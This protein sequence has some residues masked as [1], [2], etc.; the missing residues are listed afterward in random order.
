MGQNSFVM[1]FRT[2]CCRS[3]LSPI[4]RSSSAHSAT[5]S[6][7]AKHAQGDG[8]L[9]L[10]R[11]FPGSG[12]GERKKKVKKKKEKKKDKAC[13][14]FLYQPPPQKLRPVSF[15]PLPTCR[16]GGRRRFANRPAGHHRGN[17]SARFG[18]VRLST[19][20]LSAGRR[21]RATAGRRGEARP[22]SGARR[23]FPS[24]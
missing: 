18:T 14:F 13:F 1:R 10:T 12:V 6:R 3:A 24:L 5:A 16:R 15:S 8:H 7:S 2:F 4:L 19:A 17:S 22:K 23:G 21:R 20:P 11:S 9:I